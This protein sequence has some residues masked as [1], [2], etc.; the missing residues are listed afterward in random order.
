MKKTYVK[1][2]S[3][4]LCV[5]MVLPIIS[6]GASATTDFTEYRVAADGSKNVLPQNTYRWAETTG[7][8]IY[9]NGNNYVV[10]D[11]E[12]ADTDYVTVTTYSKSFEKVSEKKIVGELPI[13]GGFLSGETY[14]YIVFGANNIT[15]NESTEVFRVV[16]Y[17]KNFN[18][19]SKASI[20]GGDCFTATPFSYGGASLAESGNELTIHTSRLRFTG[21]DGLRHQSQFTIVID[22]ATMKPVNDLKTFQANHVSHSYNQFVKYD[23]DKRVLVDHGNAY[24]RSII[25]QKQAIRD[26]NNGD[27]YNEVELYKIPGKAGALCTGVTL[28]GFEVSDKNY[29]VA[30]NTVDHSKVTDYDNDV[31]DGLEVD[32]RD[33]VL[34]ISDK[35]NTDTDKVKMVYLTDYTSDNK[36]ASA[37]Y[38]VKASGDRFVVMWMEYEYKKPVN[39]HSYLYMENGIK[40]VVI[41]ENGNKLTSVKTLEGDALLSDCQPICD[42]NK[43]VW[44]YDAGNRQRR[45]CTLDLNS[46]ITYNANGG[47]VTPAGVD[48]LEG[49]SVKLPTP[50]KPVQVIYDGNG[51]TNVPRIQELELICDGWATSNKATSGEFACGSSYIPTK[52]VTLYAIWKKTPIDLSST[53]PTREGYKFLGW[54]RD[55]DAK[56]ASYLAGGKMNVPGNITIYAVWEKLPEDDPYKVT[57]NAK[58]GTVSVLSV[59]V[60]AGSTT[61]IP[62]PEWEVEITYDANEGKNAP[63]TQKVKLD[64]DGWSLCDT[65]TVGEYASGSI[66]KPTKDT[67][68]FAVWK[69]T[70]VTL[71]SEVP[72]RDGYKFLGW[73]RISDVANATYTAGGRINLAGDITLYAVWEKCAEGECTTKPVTEPTTKPVTEPTTKPVTEPTTKPVTEPTTKPVTEPTTKPVTE[74]TTKPVTEPT[75]KPVTEPT[76][77]PVKTYKV[78]YN[79]KGGTVTPA[80]AEV[81]E[82]AS[83]TLP[84]PSISVN[85][86]FD[87][88]GGKNAPSAQSVKLGCDGWSTNSKATKGDFACGSTY[89]PTKNVTLYV[90]WLKTTATL[91]SS[92]PT[93]DGYKFLG[94]SRSNTASVADC[95]AGGKLNLAGNVTL[96][97]VWEKLPEAAKT[98]KVTY[99]AK[100]GTVTPASADVIVGSSTTLPTPAMSVKVTYDANGG[101]KAPATQSVKLGCDGWA[102]SSGATKGEFACGSSYKPTNNVTLYAVWL[103]T[104]ATLTS[105]TP[106][107]AG[108]KFLGWS[109]TKD[110]ATASYAAGSKIN[111]AGDITLYAVWEKV[112]GNTKKLDVIAEDLDLIYNEMNFVYFEVD[113]A[114]EY[115][116]SYETS[117]SFV[118]MVDDDGFVI[119]TGTGTAEITVTVTDSYGNIVKD[120]CTVTVN[121]TWW[122]WIIIIFLC[123]WLWY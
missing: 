109:R 111:L 61:V 67:T 73:S 9:I 76:T 80:S 24:P 48:V 15:E 22:T 29:I 93:R 36:H 46:R 90:V 103:K 55:K 71:S 104:T 39:S 62:T 95:K 57:Y 18:V 21:A 45:G 108:Y 101:S 2:L 6:V 112:A 114:D 28:G 89:K 20:T 66:F 44:Y 98:Y 31:M 116:V 37:P 49:C 88:N 81:K 33:A 77:V 75:T 70:T 122:Q 25:L 123:G 30:M 16:K 23:G 14:N 5:A 79:A 26:D 117:D 40:Y 13:F 65:A 72:T 96:Y 43:L 56:T 58:G 119:A 34:L 50:K 4:L 115:V 107:K 102:T 38:I 60:K 35:N 52:D 92:A 11:A 86:T 8:Y 53:I 106:T 91:T 78:T 64:C 54:S 94:W 83:V 105:A 84:T 120:T 12:D 59:E 121:Y 51:G 87:A 110:A 47:T 32:L 27:V 85:I 63:K 97:A 82:G 69:K 68:F 42:N 113:G 7:S 99:N 3:V 10:V 17:D 118:A 41:D 19:I 1:L 74:P 100:G